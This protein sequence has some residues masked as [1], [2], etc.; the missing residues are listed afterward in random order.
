W[1]GSERHQPVACRA[2]ADP[3]FRA[4]KGMRD[5]LHPD[6]ERFR[7]F[8]DA[9]AEV[10]EAAGYE[11]VVLPMMEHVEVFHRLGD[12]TDIVQKEMFELDDRGG[13]RLALRPE[14]T[15]SA[16]RAF[17]EN[18]PNLPWKAWYAGPNFR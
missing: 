1:R 17:V 5:L 13:R 16:V 15:A 3:Q 10:A 11:Q 7:A 9:F 8:V 18:R 12:A 4:P 2:V 14:Q 6:A